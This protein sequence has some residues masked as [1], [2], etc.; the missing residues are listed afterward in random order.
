MI[1]MFKVK[2]YCYIAWQAAL[3]KIEVK[4]GLPTDTDMLSM[5]EKLPE[6]DYVMLFI[7]M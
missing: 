5:V 7:D 2:H 1:Y 3:K 6:V 4:S